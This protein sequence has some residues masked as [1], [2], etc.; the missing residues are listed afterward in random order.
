MLSAVNSSRTKKRN[1]FTA[2]GCT[3]EPIAI[4]FSNYNREVINAPRYLFATPLLPFNKAAVNTHHNEAGAC[5]LMAFRTMP[6]LFWSRSPPGSPA[7]GYLR[8]MQNRWARSLDP[9]KSSLFL[10]ARP[11]AIRVNRAAPRRATPRSRLMH[12]RIHPARS[13]YILTIYL[14]KRNA[15]FAQRK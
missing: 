5:L 2:P 14:R 1:Y 3:N 8:A 4:L 15:A 7:R 9:V 13:S 11:R 10:H 12:E 6:V